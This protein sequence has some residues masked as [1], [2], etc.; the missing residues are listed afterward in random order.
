MEYKSYESDSLALNPQSPFF[1]DHVTRYWWASDRCKGKSV[2]DCASGKGYGSYILSQNAEKVL[3]VDLNDNSLELASRI[4]GNKENLNYQKRD[5]F[6]L[7]EKNEKFDVITAFEVIEHIEPSETD[8]FISSLAS[9]L[10][11]NGELLLSTPNHDVVL[12]SRSS[13]P[14]FHI[15]NFRAHELKASLEKHFHNVEMIGQ[16]RRRGALYNTVFSLDFFNLRHSLRNLFKAP[17]AVEQ[18]SEDTPDQEEFIAQNPLNIDD[19]SNSP[20]E[21]SEYEFS[22][23]HWRQAGLSV[24]ICSNPK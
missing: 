9:A 14:S 24:C 4:F 7:K 15:N 2:L 16:Y 22:S 18:M 8:E 12:K 23:K 17:S 21:F 20:K 5:V 6:K 11:E 13:V 10:N 19:F 3:G 1:L